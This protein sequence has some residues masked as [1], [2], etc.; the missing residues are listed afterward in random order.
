MTKGP[1]ITFGAGRACGLAAQLVLDKED[2]DDLNYYV[3]V[4]TGDHLVRETMLC[5]E[6]REIEGVDFSAR[7]KRP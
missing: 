2:L 3:D 1:G 4:I 5:G 6:C 7:T